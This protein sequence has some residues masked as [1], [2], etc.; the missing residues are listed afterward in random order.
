[1]NEEKL[2]LADGGKLSIGTPAEM[3]RELHNG[4]LFDSHGTD[5]AYMKRFAERYKIQNGSQIRHD[6]PENFIADL[7][8]SGYILD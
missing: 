5:A 6:T 2:R 1:M 8:E 3:V 7:R 4:S